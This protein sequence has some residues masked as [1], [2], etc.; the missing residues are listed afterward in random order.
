[1][2]QGCYKTC[3]MCCSHLLLRCFGA[4]TSRLHQSLLRPCH[5]VWPGWLPLGCYGPVARLV[6]V[7]LWHAALQLQP[8]SFSFKLMIGKLEVGD[9]PFSPRGQGWALYV[10]MGCLQKT[11]TQRRDTG[12]PQSLWLPA[13]LIWV[14][15]HSQ[16]I[17]QSLSQRIWE[18]RISSREYFKQ[19]QELS[20]EKWILAINEV[21]FPK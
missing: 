3:Y 13:A 16:R 6:T 12:R 17:G 4:P 1:M 7:T 9:W 10:S 5:L 19:G 20:F 21:I 8:S 2:Q 18:L 11:R 15:S 14:K